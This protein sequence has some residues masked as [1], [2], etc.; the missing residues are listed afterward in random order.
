MFLIALLLSFTASAQNPLESFNR[1]LARQEA[2]IT[3]AESRS[4]PPTGLTEE[5]QRP[6]TAIELSE[7]KTIMRDLE[8][9][10]SETHTVDV[11]K[12]RPV[13]IQV[14]N[15]FALQEARRLQ[16]T[17]QFC[18]RASL[19]AKTHAAYQG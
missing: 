2:L 11:L 16:R 12:N 8:A 14:G 9:W 3:F 19:V 1:G 10:R 6:L 15:Q 7:L 5:C 17:N 4:C 13:D 18:A